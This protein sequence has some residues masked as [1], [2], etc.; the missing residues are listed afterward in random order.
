MRRLQLLE[1]VSFRPLFHMLAQ[2]DNSLHLLGSYFHQFHEQLNFIY[3]DE[4]IKHDSALF[5]RLRAS[6][7]GQVGNF[8]IVI[9]LKRSSLS[10]VRLSQLSVRFQHGQ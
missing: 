5:T 9:F 7:S 8:F 3:Y 6:P 4:L 10:L 2:L 1:K